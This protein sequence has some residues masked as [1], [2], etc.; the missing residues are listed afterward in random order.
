MIRR[1]PYSPRTDPLFPTPTFF[2]SPLG[3]VGEEGTGAAV[4]RRRAVPARPLVRQRHRT[5]AA[6]L[7]A[8]MARARCDARRGGLAAGA[9]RGVRACRAPAAD[10]RRAL[11]RAAVGRPRR[12]EE[13]TSELQSLMRISYAVFCLKKKKTQ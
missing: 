10:E 8:A 13:H 7:P 9:A 4:R 2:R 11:R 6:L 1:P 3:G 5:A 12:S